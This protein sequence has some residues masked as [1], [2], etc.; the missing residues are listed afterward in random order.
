M[1]AEDVFKKL[2]EAE[3]LQM[4]FGI[5]KEAVISEQYSGESENGTIELIKNI[6]RGVENNKIDAT[7]Y[8]SMQRNQ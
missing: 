6:I 5:P 3:E 8:K 4:L 1:K 7:V 2:M